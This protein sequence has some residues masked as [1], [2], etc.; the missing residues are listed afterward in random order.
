MLQIN[1]PYQPLFGALGFTSAEAIVEFFR[2]PTPQAPGSVLVRS[3]TL[4]S[5]GHSPVTVF[6]KQY[7][8]QPAAWSFVGRASKARCEYHNYAVF[9]QLGVPCADPIA[10]G[11]Q[12][13]GWSRLR[14]AFIITKA[15]PDAVPLPKFVEQDVVMRDPGRTEIK[16]EPAPPERPRA[17]LRRQLAA[18]TRCIHDAGFFHNDLHWRNVLVTGRSS[19]EPKMW[20]IDCPRGSFARWWP[21]RYRRQIK[22]LACLDKVASQYCSR[23]ERV[24][25]IREYLN[26]PR[27]SAAGKKLIR[28]VQ[29][30]RKTRWPEDWK[31]V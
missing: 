5:T 28:Q 2:G 31:G 25:F 24:A 9:R 7:E 13:D 18:W 21:W 27:L 22:D 15:I 4:A 1:A 6:Y 26:E 20:W 3:V 11:E 19:E 17:I 14:R 23:G 29:S 10:C 12:R 8:Y 16:P 30:Y